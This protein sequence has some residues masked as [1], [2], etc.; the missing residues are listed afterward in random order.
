MIKIHN[1]VENMNSEIN[2]LI[3]EDGEENQE[4]IQAMLNQVGVSSEIAENGKI[5][6]ELGVNLMKCLQK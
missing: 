3:V 2:I 1:K 6:L 4:I 5:A